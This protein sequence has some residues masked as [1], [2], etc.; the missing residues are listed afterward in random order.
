MPTN[1]KIGRSIPK[2]QYECPH[3]KVSEIFS[4]LTSDGRLFEG[5]CDQCTE[6]VYGKIS[7]ESFTRWTIDRNKAYQ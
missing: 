7:K 5:F 1:S 6:S 4:H 3:Q 2:D